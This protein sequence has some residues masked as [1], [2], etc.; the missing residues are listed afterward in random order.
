MKDPE[1]WHFWAA[2]QGEDPE[3]FF[4]VARGNASQKYVKLATNI[5]HECPV[6]VDCL[7]WALEHHEMDGIWGGMTESQRESIRR[8][9]RAAA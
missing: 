2:C 9:N 5:C 4:P 6:R 3:L 1:D 7:K 8:R